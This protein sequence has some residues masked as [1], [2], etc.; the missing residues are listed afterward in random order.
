M[1]VS[2][3]FAFKFTV[4]TMQRNCE[5]VET[6]KVSVPTTPQPLSFEEK[7]RR[8]SI[9]ASCKRTMDEIIANYCSLVKTIGCKRTQKY[10]SAIPELSYRAQKLAL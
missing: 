3:P 7:G 4:S 8:K 1:R 2:F 9:Q 5:V 6:E 10:A